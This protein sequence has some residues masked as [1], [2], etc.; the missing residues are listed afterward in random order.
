MGKEDQT[1]QPRAQE[2]KMKGEEEE[3]REVSDLE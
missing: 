1:I 2:L 3:D